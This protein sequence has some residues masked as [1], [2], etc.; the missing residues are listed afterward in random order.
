MG[1][2]GAAFSPT[3]TALPDGVPAIPTVTEDISVLV[4]G[5]GPFKTHNVNSS[6][7]VASSLPSTLVLPG[8]P[9]SVTPEGRPAARQIS[10]YTH[11]SPIPV[12]YS[13]VRSTVPAIVEEFASIHNGRRPD[14]IIHIGLASTRNYWSVET[15]A[16]RDD[17]RMGDV[18]GELGYESGEKFWK[19]QGLPPVLRP[20]PAT[21]MSTD[22][23]PAV[24]PTAPLVAPV[25][26]VS[27]Y[28]ADD[29]FLEVWK[30]F[31]PAGTDIRISHDA[32]R[33]LCEFIFY[34]SLAQALQEG[35]DR[36]VVFFHVPSWH[37]EANIKVGTETAVALIKA[38]VTC[39]ID[40]RRQT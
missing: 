10:I 3:A 17:Y 12:S 36:S 39:W 8:K 9:S 15:L 18:N 6:W 11:P 35:R 14:L 23:A 25:S 24:E 4:T 32:G 21:T 27:P 37:D 16:R 30:S 34:T 13:A 22:V 38:L 26:R 7:L 28:P 40:E 20:G 31:A 5:F 33:Y 1:D 2:Y 29:H 19:E